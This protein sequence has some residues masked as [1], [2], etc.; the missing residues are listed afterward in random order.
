MQAP[1][2]S[3]REFWPT[4]ALEAA[5]FF[6]LPTWWLTLEEATVDPSG[7][8]LALFAGASAA[9]LVC[10]IAPAFW[11]RKFSGF[12]NGHWSALAQWTVVAGLCA[13][14]GICLGQVARPLVFWTRL[15]YEDRAW[16][17]VTAGVAMVAIAV[18]SA[19]I[20][21]AG[22]RVRRGATMVLC[23]VGTGLTAGLLFAQW[24]GLSASS[25]IDRR[26]ARLVAAMTSGEMSFN[27]PN[28]L[29]VGVLL[30]AAPVIVLA[31]RIGRMPIGRGKVWLSGL[32]GVWAPLVVSVTLWSLANVAGA[33]LYWQPSLPISFAYAFGLFGD[34]PFQISWSLATLT[35]LSPGAV[36]AIWVKDATAQWPWRW[37]RAVAAAIA[38]A[39]FIHGARFWDQYTF[40]DLYRPWCWALLCGSA[41]LWLA[42]Q[43][44][45]RRR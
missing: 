28:G 37:K 45:S 39:G 9:M 6:S 31:T 14:A 18:A 20:G 3:A 24:P 43:V 12:G 4:V 30:A 38:I 2:I 1:E 5:V 16:H 44:V 33:R 41:L 27:D 22:L 26:T 11:I 15:W 10:H 36:Y 13:S 7:F 42:G 8:V 34:R 29:L 35:V 21:W 25:G 40:L 23:A 19:A 32:A 17:P